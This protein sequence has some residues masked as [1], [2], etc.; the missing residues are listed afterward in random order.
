MS[1]PAPRLPDMDHSP[2]ARPAPDLP[3]A[4]D[5]PTAPDRPAAPDQTDD[6][7]VGPRRRRPDHIEIKGL[8]AFGHHGV[9]ESERV[10]GQTFVIGLR[11]DLDLTAAAAG[12]DLSATVDYGSLAAEIVAEVAGT[13]FDLIEALAAHLADVVLAQPPVDSV[14]VRVAK[15]SAPMEVDVQEVAVILHRGRTAPPSQPGAKR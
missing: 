13:R 10:H 7:T 1:N 3:D 12:D 9:F 6:H 14:T 11:L 5:R 4:S 2:D 15:P 8:H